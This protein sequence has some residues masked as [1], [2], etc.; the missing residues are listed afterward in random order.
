MSAESTALIRTQA[1]MTSF[2]ESCRPFPYPDDSDLSVSHLKEHLIRVCPSEDEGEA[3]VSLSSETEVERV[4][5]RLT[6]QT[7]A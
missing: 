4:S 2:L 1:G 5:E 3:D 7:C 6:M